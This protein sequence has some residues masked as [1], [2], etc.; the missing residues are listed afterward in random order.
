[1]ASQYGPSIVTIT[2]SA[3]TTES[4]A[5]AG[6]FEVTVGTHALIKTNAPT[7]APPVAA[8]TIAPSCG[9]AIPDPQTDAFIQVSL[10]LHLS[11]SDFSSSIIPRPPLPSTSSEDSLLFHRILHP[12]SPDAFDILLHKHGLFDSYPLLPFNLHFGFPIR[13]M[14]S[15]SH[16]VIMP[17]NPSILSYPDTVSDY[18]TKEVNAGRLS[19]PFSHDVA[20]KILHGPFQSSS[21]IVSVQPQEPGVPDKLR[22]CQ[23]LSKA[24]KLHASVNSYIHKNDFPTRFDTASKVADIVS[25]LFYSVSFPY[26]LPSFFLHISFAFCAWRCLLISAGLASSHSLGIF[27]LCKLPSLPYHPSSS[28]PLA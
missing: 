16:T 15:L 5:S 20:E 28:M 2:S 13:H 21:L 25:F 26:L 7:S 10:S 9:F 4:F 18:L 19:G 6:T 23:H 11:Y 12:Y 3:P 8:N 1:M 17:N 24:S 22:V 27:A 14:P